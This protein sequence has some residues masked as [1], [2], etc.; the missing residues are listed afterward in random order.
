VK[1]ARFNFRGVE[2]TYARM[3]RIKTLLPLM[4]RAN[5]SGM[6]I[7]QAAA[8]MGW[9]PSSLRNWS[10]IL[11]FEWR[12]RRKRRGYKY[13]KTGWEERIVEL[14][15]KGMTH[16]QIAKQLGDVGEHNIS[17]FIKQRGL[18]IPNRNNGLMP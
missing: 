8:W 18:Q 11:G 2:M 6:N 4:H 14:R 17:R 16:A 15:K 5:D 3:E 9:S 10:R 13:D 12:N 1:R 7:N